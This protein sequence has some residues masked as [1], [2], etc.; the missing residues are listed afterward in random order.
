MVPFTVWQLYNEAMWSVST[1]LS[2]NGY[3]ICKPSTKSSRV[4]QF[5]SEN[6]VDILILDTKASQ[7][8]SML[9]MSKCSKLSVLLVCQLMVRC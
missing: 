8:D 9:I 2:T 1:F 7:F 6:L 3:M 4:E 5:L